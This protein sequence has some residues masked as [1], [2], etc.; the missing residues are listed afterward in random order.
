MKKFLPITLL[1]CCTAC[2][3]LGGDPIPQHYHLLSPQAEIS[4]AR[5]IARQLV[6]DQIEFPDYLDRPQLVTRN[7][8]NQLV[9]SASERW[10]EPLRD[11]LVRVLKENLF[12]RIPELSISNFPWQ[13]A[14]NKGL[15][16]R[17]SVNQFDGILGQRTSV[18]IRWSLTHL[19]TGQQVVQEHFNAA[20]P[21]S[22]NP[23][24]LV[25]GLSQALDQLSTQISSKLATLP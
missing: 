15:L 1:I 3:Q 6:L 13:P 24:D 2:I 16:L 17:L 21:I 22:N 9:I 11:N 18:D 25:A 7:E 12:R 19:G 23:T 4:S 20:L 5:P 8:D 10:G 14:S